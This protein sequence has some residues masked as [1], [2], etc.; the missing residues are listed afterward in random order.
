VELVELAINVV[1]QENERIDRWMDCFMLSGVRVR[2]Y[3][4]DA[5][6]D[7]YGSMW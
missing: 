6:A 2:T 5:D 4:A 3:V 1:N 7:A